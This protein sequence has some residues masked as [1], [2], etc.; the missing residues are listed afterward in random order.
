M[1]KSKEKSSAQNK[2]YFFY[3]FLWILTLQAMGYL[4]GTLTQANIHPWY[5]YLNKSSLTP[6]DITFAIIWPIL[7]ILLAIVGVEL[8]SK[9]NNSLTQQRWL[10]AFQL[11]LNWLWTP[12]FFY[13]H[14]VNMAFGIL[15]LMVLLTVALMYQLYRK[16]K[17]LTLI[18]TPYLLWITFAAYLNGFIGIAS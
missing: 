5:A 14:W 10:Y 17:N 13:L 18:L 1:N 8:F 9:K 6:P 2:T 11:V 16:H 3:L 15:V 4:L 12:L 7:Y